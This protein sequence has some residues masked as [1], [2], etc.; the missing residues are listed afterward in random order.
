MAFLCARAIGIGDVIP[1]VPLPALDWTV[2]G[3]GVLVAL[4]A[5]AGGALYGRAIEGSQAL[6]GRLSKNYYLWTALGSVAFAAVVTFGGWQAFEGTG[7]N[8]LAAALDG[9]AEPWGS[10]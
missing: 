10:P 9:R 1:K 3:Q 5:A 6:T 7:G 4:A 8:Q 2:A